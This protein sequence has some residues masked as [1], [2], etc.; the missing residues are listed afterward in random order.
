VPN[1]ISM[2]DVVGGVDKSE[3]IIIPMS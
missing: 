1:G 2:V 3:L